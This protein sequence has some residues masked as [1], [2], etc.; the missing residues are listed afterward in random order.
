MIKKLK[1]YVDDESFLPEI[2]EKQSRA[3]KSLCMWCRAMDVYSAVAKDVE[4]KRQALASAQES[5]A[6]AN[7]ELAEKQ[8]Q[9]QAVIDNV[10]A[11]KRKLA[12]AEAEAQS[13]Q[14][15]TDLAAARL[16]RAGKL[17]SALADEQVRWQSPR[18][19]QASRHP[20]RGSRA[21]QLP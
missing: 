4:P 5:L 14:E 21:C 12:E 20:R 17:T 16:G 18:P 19:R 7:A 8:A 11:L 2:V 15:Q 1:K 13:L 3:A 10:D 6:K 9:L